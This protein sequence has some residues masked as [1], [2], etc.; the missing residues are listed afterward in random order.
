MRTT[1]AAT[2]L[3]GLAA[4]PLGAADP[5]PA[6]AL[7]E[8][9]IKAHG[10][11]DALNRA[12]TL[13]RTD[14]G[15][16][17]AP[18]KDVPFTD[19]LVWQLPGRFRLTIDLGT[20]QDRSRVV[21]VVTPDKAWQTTGG[22]VTELGPDRLDELREEAYVL[23]LF[24]LTPLLKEPGFDLS[25]VPEVE[26][27]G[28]AAQGVKV[29]HKGHADTRLYFDKETGLLVQIERRASEG[30]LP[31]Q[32]RYVYADHKEFDGVRLPGRQAE[33]T[34]GKV[35]AELKDSSYRLLR[36]VNE[37]VFSKP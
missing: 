20:G 27:S 16:I 11:T 32:K 2:L 36:G 21:R 25:L 30:G 17:P 24:T 35:T 7:V 18:G 31:V 12:Q 28:R 13:R 9:A 1:V 33:V 10:G 26:V 15:T 34:N 3:L 37:A 5:D 23:W 8:R 14:T 29:V 4:L 19:E 22:T 6:R